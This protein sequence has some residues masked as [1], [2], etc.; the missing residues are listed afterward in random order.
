MNQDWTGNSKAVFSI[1][2]ASSHSTTDR[3]QRDFYATSHIE[4]KELYTKYWQDIGFSNNIWECACGNGHLVK[5][6]Q[7]LDTNLNIRSSD[8]VI[9][10]FECEKIDFLLESKNYSK[11]DIIT[12]PP[13]IYA[14]EF[15]KKALFLLE[16]NHKLAL[17]LK[18]TFL[19]GLERRKFFD[20]FPPKY[21]LIFSKRI[22]VAKNGDKK[23]FAKSSAVAYAWFI[24][25]KDC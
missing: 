1:L 13:Y 15:A 3:A 5:E 10:D 21:V 9:R 24:W 7:R 23:E 8:I 11:F 6:L 19:E 25:E 22:Q 20:K 17:F 12:N 2:G 16:P 4:I 14:L 18:L